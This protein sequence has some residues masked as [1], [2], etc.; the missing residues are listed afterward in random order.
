MIGEQRKSFLRILGHMQR[1]FHPLVRLSFISFWVLILLSCGTDSHKNPQPPIF[2]FKIDKSGLSFIHLGDRLSQLDSL[3]IPYP[4]SEVQYQSEEGYVW[5]TREMHLD[6]GKVVFEGDFF[7]EKQVTG[8]SI[9][10]SIL[11][12]IRIESP[13]LSLHNGLKTGISLGQLK[14][15]Y[16]Q[17][18]WEYTY[19]PSYRMVDVADPEM[20][21]IH[22]LF[23]EPPGIL[24]D[25]LKVGD[26]VAEGL[27]SKDLPIEAIVLL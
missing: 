2:D 26:P 24:S 5:M 20:P 6:T 21:E 7:D 19:F 11:S 4:L 25:T 18:S 13:M 3:E 1:Q 23:P 27:L 14:S 15:F 10:Q 9:Q 16:P 8:E 17:S 22:Y 12:R